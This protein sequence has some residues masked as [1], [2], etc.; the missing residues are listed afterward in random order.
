VKGSVK[1]PKA[2][3]ATEISRLQAIETASRAV[4]AQQTRYFAS[5]SVMDL[6]E[7]KKSEKILDNLLASGLAQR[8]TAGPSL[9]EDVEEAA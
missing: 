9:F 3:D 8:V 4:R 5:R 1:A 7:C 6:A 2:P